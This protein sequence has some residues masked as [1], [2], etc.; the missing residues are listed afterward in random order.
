MFTVEE[1][2]EV[3]AALI[4]LARSDARVVAGA[5]VGSLSGAVEAAGLGDRW[6]DLDLTFGLE[7]GVSPVDVLDDWAGALAERW[8]AVRLFDLQSV[9]TLY[10]VFLF[11]GWLQVDL[12]AT[13]GGVSQM[14]PKFRMLFGDAVRRDVA[15]KPV[16]SELYGLCVHHALR[17][18]VSIERGRMWAAEFWI[19]ELRHEALA[20]ASVLRGLPARYARSFHELPEPMMELAAASLVG[21]VERDELLRALAAA[22]ELLVR[23]AAD[24]EVGDEAVM[25]A[26]RLRVLARADLLD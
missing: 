5:E 12:S 1:R 6:S 10:R 23:V 15:P 3:R 20:L 19:G 7:P 14:G 17:T 21:S 22:V 16:G 9:D 11:P 4:E 13:P 26:D 18:R 24:L 2:G 8:G 25:P